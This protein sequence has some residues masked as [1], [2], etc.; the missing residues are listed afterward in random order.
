MSRSRLRRV[1]REMSSR[2][3]A[4]RAKSACGIVMEII[5]GFC[6]ATKEL[7]IR[8]TSLPMDAGWPLVNMSL[9]TEAQPPACGTSKLARSNWFSHY[10]GWGVAVT[11]S[12]DGKQLACNSN[13]RPSPLLVEVESGAQRSL[14]KDAV[15][16]GLAWS[17]RGNTL[18]TSDGDGQLRI[19]DVETLKVI[20]QAE[21]SKSDVLEWSPDGK[22]LALHH[23]EAKVEIR[24]AKTLEVART[25]G[26]NAN[27]TSNTLAWL[28]DSERLVVSPGDG[29]TNG[30]VFNAKSGERLATFDGNS[31][32]VAILKDTKQAVVA[33]GAQ[34]QFYDTTTGKKLHEGAERGAVSA[35]ITKLSKNGREVYAPSHDKV[36]V[37]DAETCE[38][39]RSFK[40]V[41]EWKGHLLEVDPSPDNLSLAMFFRR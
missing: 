10:P 4:E 13:Q 29:S 21:C 17:P 12:P 3:E 6:W 2:R 7:W 36:R 23:H 19:W 35:F 20:Q 39:L 18:A 25:F 37:F 41:R 34:L 31:H 32:S 40:I 8:S 14:S 26:S 27:G 1:L 33:Y 28:S 16:F 15:T 9:G 24:D 22:W 5:K 38:Q 11:F 30:G